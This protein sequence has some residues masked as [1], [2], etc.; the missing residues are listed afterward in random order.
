MP[1]PTLDS[2]VLQLLAELIRFQERTKQREPLKAKARRRYVCGLKE[3][4]KYAKADRIRA[5]I[6]A[7]NVEENKSEGGLDR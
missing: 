6:V 3:V 1:N 5:V 2:L 4:R 7:P